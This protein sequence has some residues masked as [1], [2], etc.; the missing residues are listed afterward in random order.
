VTWR[1]RLTRRLRTAWRPPVLF[2]TGLADDRG[3]DAGDGAGVSGGTGG[4]DVQAAI[5]AF[6][7]WCTEH[8][9]A[10]CELALSSRW[11]LCSAHAPGAGAASIR[12]EAARQW[13]HYHDADATVLAEA[14][15]CRE[16]TRSDLAMAVAAPRAL[17]EGLATQAKAH[18]VRITSVRPWWVRAVQ[19]CLSIQN[20]ETDST[21][22]RLAEP[23]LVTHVRTGP[24]QQAEGRVQAIWVEAALPGQQSV[25]ADGVE[26]RLPVQGSADGLDGPGTSNGSSAA[27]TSRAV[28]SHKAMHAVLMGEAAAWQR[29]A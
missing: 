3:V 21:V 22:L 13:A 9:G 19:T 25:Q 6:G 26:L 20:D 2:L 4:G 16:V 12:E 7:H 8:E 23:G 17:I 27:C 28:W 15:T 18:G 24:A 11:L 1:A 10:V 5:T 14:W 29:Q